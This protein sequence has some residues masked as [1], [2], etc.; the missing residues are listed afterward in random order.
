MKKTKTTKTWSCLQRPSEGK[1]TSHACATTGQAASRSTNE[2]GFRVQETVLSCASFKPVHHHFLNVASVPFSQFFT[3][4]KVAVFQNLWKQNG[5]TTTSSF[6][7]NQCYLVQLL[8]TLWSVCY[9]LWHSR[10][11]LWNSAPC[12]KVRLMFYWLLS[13]PPGDYRVFPNKL[14]RVR[15][16]RSEI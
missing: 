2:R 12:W 7:L 6:S 15:L 14:L 9:F 4:P 3:G 1:A 10:Q 16:W 8:Y 11:S 13:V 5:L